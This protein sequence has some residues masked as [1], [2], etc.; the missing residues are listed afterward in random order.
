MGKS[1]SVR[2]FPRTDPFAIYINFFSRWLHGFVN[3]SHIISVVTASD[4]IDI[5]P[6]SKAHAYSEYVRNM[7]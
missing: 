3:F 1:K 6:Y 7:H 2:N 4:I 5:I